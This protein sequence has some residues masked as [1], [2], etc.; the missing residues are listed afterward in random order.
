[1]MLK[2]RSI[3]EIANLRVDYRLRRESLT[4]V[5]IPCWSVA[6]GEQVVLFGPSGCGKSTLLHVLSGV[7]AATAG[8][9]QVC[10]T[11][12]ARMNEEQRDRFRACHVGYVL[13]NFNLLAG[14]T[15]L[16]NV[17]MGATFHSGRSDV[18]EARELLNMVGLAERRD[19]RPNELSFGEQQ[20]VAIARALIKRP[21]LVLADEPT[22]ALDPRNTAQVVRL[23]RSACA[24][25]NS[26]LI[27][28]THEQGV[29]AEFEHQVAY[30]ELNR[31]WQEDEAVR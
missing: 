30:G 25:R 16:E 11:D 14:Y 3:V 21:D 23:L 26:T 18:E 29:I 2:Q 9:V 8:R 28:V 22:G 5:D 10:G 24:A 20:R 6:S 4:V 27:V 1:M 17:L 12:L 15:A 31:A 7:I 19:H 13:Q